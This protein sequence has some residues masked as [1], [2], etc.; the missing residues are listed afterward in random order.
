MTLERG[1]CCSARRGDRGDR[2]PFAV[3]SSSDALGCAPIGR[4]GEVP[5]AI[6]RHFARARTMIGNGARVRIE[7]PGGAPQHPADPT[8]AVPRMSRG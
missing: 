3:Y 5:A 4:T 7:S 1:T 6:G 2:T 8:A